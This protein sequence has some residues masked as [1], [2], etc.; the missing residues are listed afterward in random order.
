M[1]SFDYEKEREIFE[2]ELAAGKFSII[3]VDNKEDD[4]HSDGREDSKEKRDTSGIKNIL[5][6]N[7]LDSLLKVK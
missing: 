1:L 2:A 3:T 7:C 5:S 6:S 4:Y